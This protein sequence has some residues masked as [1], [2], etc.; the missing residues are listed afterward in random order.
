MAGVD[1]VLRLPT[2][3]HEFMSPDYNTLAANKFAFSPLDLTNPAKLDFLSPRLERKCQLLPR[4]EGALDVKKIVAAE[5]RIKK[6]A[7]GPSLQ[8]RSS[9]ETKLQGSLPTQVSTSTSAVAAASTMDVKSG[10]ITK[11][12]SNF[13]LP[14]PNLITKEPNKSKPM[15]SVSTQSTSQK[16]PLCE[17]KVEKNNRGKRAR[18]E[19]PESPAL[20]KHRQSGFSSKLVVKKLDPFP[21]KEIRPSKHQK[22]SHFGESESSGLQLSVS[23]KQTSSTNVGEPTVSSISAETQ[24]PGL[25]KLNGTQRTAFTSNVP[26]NKTNSA[27]DSFS[28]QTKEKLANIRARQKLRLAAAIPKTEVKPSTMSPTRVAR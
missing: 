16:L 28:T 13:I 10:S 5:S 4:T 9:T 17:L 1:P 7:Q 3:R 26:S 12:T 21:E 22:V 18:V 24:Q 23:Q 11:S 15:I 8:V 2:Q 20:P 27:D 14:P 6:P 19:T 25:S